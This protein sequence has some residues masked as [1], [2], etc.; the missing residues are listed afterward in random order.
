MEVISQSLMLIPN[1][2]EFQR[3]QELNSNFSKRTFSK[4]KYPQ[5]IRLHANAQFKRIEE[6]HPY[7]DLKTNTENYSELA[8]AAWYFSGS[9]KIA[10]SIREHM[11]KAVRLNQPIMIVGEAGTGRR[12]AAQLIHK[13]STSLRLHE[14]PSTKPWI[15]LNPFL[16]EKNQPFSET[17]FR[18]ILNLQDSEAATILINLS[19]G[20]TIGRLRTIYLWMEHQEISNEA[21]PI[22]WIVYLDP[23]TENSLKQRFPSLWSQLARLRIH[24]PTL[25]TRGEDLNQLIDQ[26]IA[27]FAQRLCKPVPIISFQ[28]RQ[29]LHAHSFTGHFAELRLVLERIV[30]QED[31]SISNENTLPSLNKDLF[32]VVPSKENNIQQG[33]SEELLNQFSISYSEK[34]VKKLV[35]EPTLKKTFMLKKGKK[36]LTLKQQVQDFER[37]IVKAMM[38]ECR[39]NQSQCAKYLGVSR[40]TIFKKIN[41]LEED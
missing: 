35:T 29:W 1:I 10:Q 14:N 13:M 3:S 37:E 8:T 16:N 30:L 17:N 15:E 23:N 19:Q 36:Y 4:H 40:R 24:L 41:L 31:Q 22:Q 7:F 12:Y 27:L 26:G 11:V 32:D 25:A 20:Y 18:S 28:M 39:G 38:Y 9:S 5:S 6:P 33:K 21:G 2:M 34:K